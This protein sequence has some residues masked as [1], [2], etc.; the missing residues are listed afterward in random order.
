LGI[1]LVI[2]SLIA[3]Y[4]IPNKIFKLFGF[5]LLTFTLTMY[6]SFFVFACTLILFKILMALYFAQLNDFKIS[7]KDYTFKIGHFILLAISSL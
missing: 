4:H 2:L 5:L 1:C 3:I 7:F 6:Q